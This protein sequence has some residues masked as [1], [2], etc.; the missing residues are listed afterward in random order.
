MAVTLNKELQKEVRDAI[1]KRAD[2][3]GYAYRGRRE[4]GGF[5]TSLISDPEIG[6]KLSEYMPKGN[7][8]TYI[9]DAVLN[10]YTKDLINKSLADIE[11]VSIVSKVYSEESVEISSK[12]F[13]HICVNSEKVFIICDGTVAKWESALRKALETASNLPNEDNKEIKICLKLASLGT[14]TSRGDRSLITRG[15]S[16]IGANVFFC[17]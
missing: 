7:I 8:R 10:K 11:P 6:G 9:K 16:F 15:L 5:M 17:S 2:E 12:G 1:Y 14:A 4:N 13:I 3:Y